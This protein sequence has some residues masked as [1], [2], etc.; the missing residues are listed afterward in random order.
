MMSMPC[1]PSTANC[2]P[3][4]GRRRRWSSWW[5]WWFPPGEWRS[6]PRRSSHN[7]SDGRSEYGGGGLDGDGHAAQVADQ[8]GEHAVH[9]V[10]NGQFG[11]EVHDD[12]RAAVAAPVTRARA[13]W[14]VRVSQAVAHAEVQ[15]HAETLVDALRL[16]L[17]DDLSGLLAEEAHTAGLALAGD[18][19]LHGGHRARV[20]LA[21]GGGDLGAAPPRVMRHGRI[22]G[23]VQEGLDQ[24]LRQLVAAEF[25]GADRRRRDDVGH[26]VVLGLGQ[27]D[28]EVGLE[29]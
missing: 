9:D 16:L 23:R 7:Q 21:V 29:R 20:A 28:V 14:H 10:A 6:K 15:G 1:R 27:A 8:S 2:S 13:D 26:A 22:D 24:E 5:H 12:D 3:T 19:R 4:S 17:E 25:G 11:V 18:D